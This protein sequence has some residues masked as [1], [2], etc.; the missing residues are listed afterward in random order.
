MAA[1]LSLFAAGLSL[2]C[3]FP[4]FD[5]GLSA[6]LRLAANH[7]AASWLALFTDLGSAAMMIPLAIAGC[8]RLWTTRRPREAI[9][10]FGTVATG[11][12]CVEGLKWLIDRDRPPVAGR[13]VDVATASFPSSHSAGS[14]L[15]IVALSLIFRIKRPL[16]IAGLA[17]VLFVGLS[18][19]LLG[20]HWASDILAGW[21]L[22]LFWATAFHAYGPFSPARPLRSRA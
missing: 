7:P 22:G 16:S 13:L 20:V 11:R 12:L 17:F 8:I 21:G 3:L 5:A 18:R 9:W 1:G 19:A 4:M 10:L 15:T 14:M 6:S 2:W